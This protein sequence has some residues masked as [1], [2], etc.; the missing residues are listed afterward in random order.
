M[1]PTPP[2]TTVPSPRGD[3]LASAEA[4]EAI[5]M[6][7]M[8]TAAA[9]AA[10]LDIGENIEGGKSTE[11]GGELRRVEKFSGVTRPKPPPPIVS[12]VPAPPPVAATAAATAA[13][14]AVAVAALPPPLLPAAAMREFVLESIGDIDRNEAGGGA[15]DML[16]RFSGARGKKKKQCKHVNRLENGC[17]QGM[18]FFLRHSLTPA[19]LK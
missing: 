19:L 9:A 11:L 17:R 4:L 18:S 5:V 13:A 15:I 16:S 2:P 1:L 10:L 6:L 3:T 12:P 14:A 7:A 8:P